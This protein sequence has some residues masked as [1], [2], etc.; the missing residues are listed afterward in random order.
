MLPLILGGIALAAVGY[1]VKE[2]CESEGCPW[3]EPYSIR[4]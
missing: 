3:D 1:G 2:I 4:L